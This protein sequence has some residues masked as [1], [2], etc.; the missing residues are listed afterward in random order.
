MSNSNLSNVQVRDRW[1]GGQ[2]PDT[3]PGDGGGSSG[4]VSWDAIPDKPATFPPSAHTH[5]LSD[6]EQSGATDGQIATW[7]GTN[8]IPSDPAPSGSWI[9]AVDGSE[10]PELISDGSGRLILV[11][12]P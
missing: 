1:V 4:T 7:N 3:T 2:A 6:L 9:P 10:P 5:P 8:W 11:G 12:Y